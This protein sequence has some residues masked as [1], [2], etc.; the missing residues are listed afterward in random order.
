[1]DSLINQ[2]NNNLSAAT[3]LSWVL[4]GFVVGAI[5]HFID[6]SD[7]RGGIAGTIVT[8]ILGAIAGGFVANLI[9]GVDVTGFNLTSIVIAVVGALVLSLLERVLLRS[10]RHIKTISPKER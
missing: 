2:L 3:I 10:D 4:F 1:M 8:G 7:V 6:P 5:A 9:L